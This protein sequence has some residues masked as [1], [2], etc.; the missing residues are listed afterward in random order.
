[1][2]NRACSTDLFNVVT[3]GNLS[4]TN[5]IAMAPLTR[6][7]MGSGGVP[8]ALHA[9][10]YSQ[11]ATAGL[12]ISEATN[13]SLQG[14][15]YAYT[16]GIWTDAQVAGWRLVTDAVHEA[17]GKIVCQLWHV[18]RFSHTS[19]Q[20]EGGAPVA[21]SAIQ[22]EGHTFTENGFERVS[23]PRAL[24][25]DEVVSLSGQY[26]HAA[27]CAKRAG[28]DGVEVHSANSY[29]LDQFIRDSTNKRTDR[30]G[31][32]IEN[33]TRLTREI[34]EAVLEVWDSGSVGI[35]LSPTTPDAGNTAM[36]SQVMETYGYLIDKL[37]DY[38]LAYLHFVEGATAGSRD[39]PEGVD[40]D[41]LRKRFKGVYMGN[42]G[43]DLE[44]AIERREAGLIDLVAFGRP[45]IAN[46]D[47]VERL[48]HN[49]P[50]SEST[51]DDYYG[52]GAKGYTD[53]DRATA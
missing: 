4:L 5:R 15:G 19:L 47:L 53:W 14:R 41:A 9:T 44:L 8:T 6:S 33:R 3:V 37:N 21:P 7:R 46:P 35:R 1:M 11:R 40:L 2:S 29:L 28:F 38:D 20:P 12:I 34:V 49:L 25:T 32:S 45:F 39:L 24:T 17:G 50:L 31:G 26:R 22:A 36:D 52:G 51:R 13:I 42:N 43:Y 16:P 23:V 10:Y 30:Y 27:E 48:K 18:G